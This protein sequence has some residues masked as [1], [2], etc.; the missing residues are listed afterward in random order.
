[1]NNLSQGFP[2]RPS[3]NGDK[4]GEGTSAAHSGVCLGTVLGKS[5][6]PTHSSSCASLSQMP[7]RNIITEKNVHVF[8]GGEIQVVDVGHR[9]E[10]SDLNNVNYT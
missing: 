2:I 8:G 5:Y 3:M 10:F 9:E 7:Q 4:E 6:P 1:M